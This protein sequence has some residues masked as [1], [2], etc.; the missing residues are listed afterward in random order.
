MIDQII[1]CLWG[2]FNN[3]NTTSKKGHFL[4]Y[5]KI[6]CLSSFDYLNDQTCLNVEPLDLFIEKRIL[7]LNKSLKGF[8]I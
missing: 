3:L 2:L 5:L 4:K 7:F 8:I 6:N 1:L